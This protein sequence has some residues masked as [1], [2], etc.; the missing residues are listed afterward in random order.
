MKKQRDGRNSIKFLLR[1]F[2]LTLEIVEK[3]GQKGGYATKEHFVMG[4]YDFP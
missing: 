1:A 3:G 2:I 4:G